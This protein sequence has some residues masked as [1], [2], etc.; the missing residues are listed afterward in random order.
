M[1]SSFQRR[2]GLAIVLHNNEVHLFWRHESD[3]SS[4]LYRSI[5]KDGKVFQKK[6][7]L[8]TVLTKNSSEGTLIG[9]HAT[10]HA[11]GSGVPSELFVSEHGKH[12]RFIHLSEK[13][14]W[15]ITTQS[16]ILT[17]PT[18]TAKIPGKKKS[19]SRLVAFSTKTGKNIFQALSQSD[20]SRFRSS[21]VVLRTRPHSFESVRITPFYTETLEEDILLV[22]IAEDE[23]KRL[24]LGAALFSREDP[25]ELVWRSPFPLWS[26][27][28]KAN[29]SNVRFLG[30]F[31]RG[32]YFWLYIESA[33]RGIEYFPMAQYWKAPR[34]K[35]APAAIA[36]PKRKRGVKITL[37]K[38]V[39]NP[40]LEPRSEYSWEAFASF[41]PAAIALEGKIHLLYRAQG[42][43][44]QSVLGYAGSSDGIRIE[45][46]SSQPVFIPSQPKSVDDPLYRLGSGG[47][48]GGCEDPRIVEINGIL[49]LIYVAFD[50]SQPPGVALTSISKENF[51]RKRWRWSIPRLI[52]RPGQIQKNWVLFP[53]KINGKFA[54]LHGLTPH[55]KIE[56]L[57]TLDNLG[58]SRFIESL[59]SHGGRG[60]IDTER[61]AAWDNI[62]RGAGAPPLAT[63]YGWL[64]F[65]HGMDM[66]DPGKYKV[67]VMLLDKKDPEKILRRA[68][69]PVLEPNTTYENSGH[70]QGVV[71]VCGAVIKDNTL[72]VYY[73]ASDR[74]CAVATAPLDTFLKD[75]LKEKPPT[76]QKMHVRK[77]L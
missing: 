11:N 16:S 70:K 30:G 6:I 74:S 76:L 36:L 25:S 51:L 31:P 7:D 59:S 57:D 67:G 45:E 15:K 53:E 46:R 75:L 33:E 38:V 41:N 4:S 39:Q 55:I 66:R 17:G 2:Q 49:Y 71:Y 20:L 64:V 77:H 26:L 73:G 14:S 48:T 23:K 47:G 35:E 5:S 43:N 13:Q 61:L 9:K 44:G 1:P 21:A 54:V 42:Y 60:Y 34:F 56:Y 28:P 19:K 63:P 69:E 22:Y 40:I 12:G 50:G 62:V 8:I 3:S 58:K 29:L 52:S 65:Y 27:D 32:K 24:S 10:F 18:V 68:L 37:E 72:F